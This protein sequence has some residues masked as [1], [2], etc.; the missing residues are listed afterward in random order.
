M[1]CIVIIN[2]ILFGLLFIVW[3]ILAIARPISIFHEWRIVEIVH[4]NGKIDYKVEQNGFL[5]MPFLYDI[6][7]T[8]FSS[9]EGLSLEEAK[10]YIKRREEEYKK[11]M[12]EKVERTKII[13]L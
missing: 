11:V 7:D 12:G 5:A 10:N 2:S 8:I 13:E 6:D 1:I 3:L 4:R 9:C